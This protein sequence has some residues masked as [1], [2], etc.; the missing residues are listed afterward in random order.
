M[1]IL[2]IAISIG[3]IAR[4][5][6]ARSLR[7][8][9]LNGLVHGI[10]VAAECVLFVAAFSLMIGLAPEGAAL[11]L[12]WVIVV[13][14]IVLAVQASSLSRGFAVIGSAEGDEFLPRCAPLCSGFCIVGAAIAAG[15]ALLW[16]PIAG[17]SAVAIGVVFT[18]S[19]GARASSL[20]R[21]P[22]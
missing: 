7:V 14:C 5:V 19:A 1:M 6:A 17:P 12:H 4:L 10:A 2:L 15:E 22:G 8:M 13:W 9:P 16:T 3:P 18:V 11:W 21:T 20:L